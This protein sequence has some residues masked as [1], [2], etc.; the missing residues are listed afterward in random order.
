M[1]RRP[2]LFRTAITALCLAAGLLVASTSLDA[3]ARPAARTQ[4]EASLETILR[5]ID[6]A[7]P[8][9]HSVIADSQS[10]QYTAIVDD[11]TIESGKLYYRKTAHGPELALEITQ[12][13]A[14]QKTFIY[15][16]ETGWMYVPQSRQVQK[17]DLS[18]NRSVVEQFLLLGLGGSGHDL[19]KSFTVR[20][21]GRTTLDGTPTVELEL[22]PRQA[23]LSRNIVAIDLWYSTRTWVAV[24][25]KVLQQGGD[26][27]QLH[28]T[29]I[30]LNPHVPDSRFDTRFPGATVV[31][32]H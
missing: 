11:H 15:K 29:Q 19:L 2:S 18:K 16:N 14:S 10:D 21:V 13:P 17:Y 5:Q 22:K 26:Y 24:Q 6:Q 28:Y 9:I 1:I 8:H 4:T 20:L 30:E 31:T 7:A 3:I 27:R 32:P 23:D 12:P 25:Q